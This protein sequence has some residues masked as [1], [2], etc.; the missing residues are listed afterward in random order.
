MKFLKTQLILFFILPFFYH[1]GGQNLNF[2]WAKQI[3]GISD[4]AGYTLATDPVGNVYTSGIFKGTVDFDPGFGSFYMT[5]YGVNDIFITKFD[6]NGNFIWAKQI[7][8]AS[9]DYVN[10]ICLDLSGN[11]YLT[12]FFFGTCDFDPSTNTSTLTA[13]NFNDMYVLKLD[14]F[15]N[16]VFVKQV[17]SNFFIYGNSILVD[18]SGDIYAAGYFYGTADFDPDVPVYNLSANN[19]DAFIL[20]LNALGAFVFVKQIV[21]NT[22]SST[23]ICTNISFDK[24]NNILL[25]G[26]FQGNIDADPG[27]STTTLTSNGNYDVF[28]IKLNSTGNFIWGLSFGGVLFSDYGN[29][30]TTDNM[31]NIYLTGSFQNTTDFDPSVGVFTMT[32]QGSDDVFIA[33]YDSTGKF[34]WCKQIGDINQD[35]GCKITIDNTKNIYTAGYFSNTPDFDPGISTYS[36]ASSGVEDAF[37]LK[38]DSLGNF[39]WA[40]KVGSTGSDYA[41]DLKLDNSMN[42]FTTGSFNGT[43]N[44]DPGLSSYSLTTKGISDAFTC[45]FGTCS[46]P[47][48]PINTTSF[49]NQTICSGNSATLSATSLTGTINWYSSTSSNVVNTGTLFITSTLTSGTYTFYAESFS[50]APSL[51]KTSITVSVNPLP[52]ININTTNTLICSQPIQQSATLSATGGI[53]YTWTPGGTGNNIVVSPSITTTYTTTGVDSNGCQNSS[54]FTQSVSVCALIP[55]NSDQILRISIFPNPAGNTLNVFYEND[56][57]SEIHIINSLGQTVIRNNFQNIMDIS[58]LTDGCY[59][60]F[61]NNRNGL[62]LARKTFII[63]KP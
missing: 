16:F 62:T 32:P 6:P 26:H 11:I 46:P 31:N 43:A 38:L 40:R 13:V 53:N 8:G 23:N 33:K 30:I 7:G 14:S 15:G 55:F 48:S 45:K 49:L 4:E 24:S 29:G 22:M 36:I 47:A 42:V 44:F 2:Q 59:T 63:N 60:I 9:D 57:I 37:I 61:F 51:I 12:G 18:N 17:S 52:T 50:C 5:S 54:I 27:I 21:G 10:S 34:I 58:N 39:I 3:A 28:T 1:A 19:G 25:T 56:Q 20:K 35:I 41:Y